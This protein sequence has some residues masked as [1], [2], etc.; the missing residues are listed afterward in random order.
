MPLFKKRGRKPS[1]GTVKTRDEL[2]KK[3]HWLDCAECGLDGA[4][5]DGD[6]TRLTCA[7][8]VQ[9]KLAPPKA[10]AKKL[11]GDEKAIRDK[12]REERKQYLLA[13]LRGEVAPEKKFSFGRGWH[14]RLLFKTELDGKDRYFSEGKE[15]TKAQYAK[16][17]KVQA[18]KA[19]AKANKPARVRGWHF[20]EKFVDEK[21]NLYKRGK[22]V[23]KA[24]KSPTVKELEQL[25]AQQLNGKVKKEKKERKSKKNA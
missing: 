5:V 21:G 19:D 16:I 8:C 14:R 7:L 18:T 4:W 23:K 25:M 15:V 24:P 10:P 13:V 12:R 1:K 2:K 17:E 11:T 22:L 6:V 20:M 9:K 3:R